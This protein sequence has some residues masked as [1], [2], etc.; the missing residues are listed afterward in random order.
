MAPSA[1]LP[2]YYA[3][4]GVPQSAD[5]DTIRSRYRK[6]ALEKHPDRRKNE[7]NTTAECQLVSLTSDFPLSQ[8]HESS[9]MLYIQLIDA[10]QVLGDTDKRRQYDAAYQATIQPRQIKNQKIAE[11]DYRQFHSHHGCSNGRKRGVFSWKRTPRFLP[12]KVVKQFLR[13]VEVAEFLERVR[14]L[15]FQEQTPRFLPFEHP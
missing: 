1:V 15:R 8:K 2:G 7:P 14:I 10:Y 5:A 11:L 9:L 4:R 12:F 3:I 6:L 13:K